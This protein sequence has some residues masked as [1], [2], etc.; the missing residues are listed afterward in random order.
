M[1]QLILSSNIVSGL[2]TL[3]A[4]NKLYENIVNYLNN[5]KSETHFLDLS[6]N[7][8]WV[9]HKMLLNKLD[10]YGILGFPYKWLDSNL[11]G[12]THQ[13]RIQSQLSRINDL[14][15][16]PQGSI[17]GPVIFFIYINI[18]N[19]VHSQNL[20]QYA[21]DTALNIISNAIK[22]L[23][24]KKI[25]TRSRNLLKKSTTVHNSFKAWILKS[26]MLNLTHLNLT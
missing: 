4:H 16:T 21:T 26:T 12:R 14:H 3:D 22:N 15:R 19:C 5:K 2:G 17:L 25:K 11:W 6:K 20:I 23:E 7:F 8:D 10:S 18:V 13:V 1:V 9:D 24:I